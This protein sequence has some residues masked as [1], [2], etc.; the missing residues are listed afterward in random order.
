MRDSVSLSFA[1]PLDVPAY[2]QYFM[3]GSNSIR[4]YDVQ[5]LGK[6]LFGK[7]QLIAT[8]A[9]EFSLLEL[10]EYGNKGFTV[11]A[12]LKAAAFV[13][14]GIAWSDPDDFNGHR[15]KTGFGVGLRFLVPAVDVFRVDVAMNE[16]GDVTFQF[17]TYDKPT[18]Q[19]L[20]LR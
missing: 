4:G 5:E 11:E 2:L 20:W 18:A 1:A 14:W 8:A 19:R 17:G 9:Y 7:N 15:G 13:D 3:G 6:E 16:D 12:G 10:R